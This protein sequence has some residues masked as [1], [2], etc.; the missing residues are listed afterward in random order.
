MKNLKSRQRGH[1]N[2]GFLL[3]LLW[4]APW[5]AGALVLGVLGL[6]AWLM[7]R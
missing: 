3:F 5:I 6:I 4:Y 2:Y 1:G 7:F